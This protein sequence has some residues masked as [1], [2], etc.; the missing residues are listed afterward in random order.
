MRLSCEKCSINFELGGRKYLSKHLWNASSY[1]WHNT[2]LSIIVLPR[3]CLFTFFLCSASWAK[4]VQKIW[5]ILGILCKR[6]R[7]LILHWITS[8][9]CRTKFI[10]Q[11]PVLK[12]L[13]N[14][15]SLPP[16]KNSSTFQLD[17][18]QSSC[19]KYLKFAMKK[20]FIQ[21]EPW[22]GR[23]WWD[24]NRRRYKFR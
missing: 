6:K 13:Y 11:R 5:F 18:F 14:M 16:N 23:V 2:A 4:I 3:M 9:C 10:L 19:L 21:S 15:L 24:W 8:N 1:L 17:G 22:G 12:A 20:E 7:K